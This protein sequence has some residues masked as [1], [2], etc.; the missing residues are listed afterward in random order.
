MLTS[1]IILAFEITLTE[2]IIFQVGALL[3]GFAINYFWN[4]K[5]SLP[6]IENKPLQDTSINEADEWRLK[7]YEQKDIQQ[8][9]ED[10]YKAEVEDCWNRSIC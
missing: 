1:V 2:I 9:L 3:L 4:S 6:H 7:Y 8:K 10:S 5:K